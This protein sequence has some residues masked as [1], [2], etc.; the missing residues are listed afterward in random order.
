M[1]T[2]HYI[3]LVILSVVVIFGGLYLSMTNPANIPV[4][5]TPVIS[6]EP[7]TPTVVLLEELGTTVPAEWSAVKDNSLAWNIER[8]GKIEAIT[9]EGKMTKSATV[10]MNQLAGVKTYLAQ[11]GFQPNLQN[12]ANGTLLNVEGY[13][14]GLIVCSVA[15]EVSEILENADVPEVFVKVICGELKG[16]ETQIP[17][18]EVLAAPVQNI[19]MEIVGTIGEMETCV[20]KCF[21]LT[22]GESKIKTLYGDMIL[23]SEQW[24][25][26]DVTALKDSDRVIVQGQLKTGQ[27]GEMKLWAKMITKVVEEVAPV[28]MAN[29]ASTNCATLG[30]N[31]TNLK[32][33]EGDAGYCVFADGRICEEWA[34]FQTSV[35]NPPTI[36]YASAD[37]CAFACELNESTPMT[38]ECKWDTEVEDGDVVAGACQITNSR[39]CG[40]FGQ[41]TCY[42]HPISTP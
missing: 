34:L 26:L 22:D 32:S 16:D 9:L 37:S 4:E 30:G 13:Q 38:G 33:P 39:H 20:G 28:A 42:C 2:K 17:L 27:L 35:C 1:R 40:V 36:P 31:S 8:G 25:D 21:V 24:P 6:E 12:V 18:A 29:P 7:K 5:E 23:E 41:C 11:K 10:T 19:E 15:S 14:A 3:S